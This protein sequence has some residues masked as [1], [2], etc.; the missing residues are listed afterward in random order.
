MM[1]SFDGKYEVTADPKSKYLTF[2]FINESKKLNLTDASGNEMRRFR[3]IPSA[4]GRC[5]SSKWRFSTQN[6]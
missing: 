1:T 4:E 3:C 2:T 5:R 6:C